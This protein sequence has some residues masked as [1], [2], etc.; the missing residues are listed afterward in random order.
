MRMCAAFLPPNT[1]HVSTMRCVFAPEYATRQPQARFCSQIRSGVTWVP[2]GSRGGNVP[3]HEGDLVL[4][5]EVWGLT[6]GMIRY[7]STE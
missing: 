7:L 3:A 5:H 6:H 2:R 1:P 4:G